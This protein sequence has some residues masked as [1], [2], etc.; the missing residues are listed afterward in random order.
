VFTFT[1]ADSKIQAEANVR[2]HHA[3]IEILKVTKQD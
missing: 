3:N 2:R 1:I